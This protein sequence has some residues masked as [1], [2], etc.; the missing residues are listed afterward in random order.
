MTWISTIPYDDAEG[1][2][3]K[4]YDRIKGPDDNVDNIMLA[5]SLRPHTMEGH[6]T[7]YKYVLHHPR[8]TL[9]K[10]YL[11]TIGVWVSL[12][13]QCN[14]CLEHHF[15]GMSRLLDDAE[16]AAQIQS[17]MQTRN[18]PA[19]FSG[20]ELAGLEYVAKLTLEA[21]S[22]TSADIERLRAAGF[23]DGEILEIN[24]VTAYFAYA[25]RMVLGLG[26]DTEGDIIGLSPND[27]SDPDN[28]SHS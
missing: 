23:D 12:L 17:A 14:Y 11:E 24:Q 22:A 25:N 21:A 18:L 6:M 9:P 27:S 28:W 26:I 10:A 15:A 2:L 7:L 16:R 1:A 3:K 8:N 5:H 20:R 4:L 13:N 19:A